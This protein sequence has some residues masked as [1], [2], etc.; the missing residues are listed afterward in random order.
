M[1]I[2]AQ[3][4]PPGV[5]NEEVCEGQPVPDLIATGDDIQWFDDPELTNLV[6]E[7]NQ[8]STGL[9]DPGTYTFYAV[10]TVNECL[11][12]PAEAV[13]TIH[14]LPAVTLAEINDLCLNAPPLTLS[15]G[16]PD[17]GTYSG[18]GVELNPATGGIAKQIYQL[19]VSYL[20]V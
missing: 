7:G 18:P 17:G 15:G 8:F 11:S 14:E 13:L 5:S 16:S 3:P 20:H 6:H 9:T 12:A 10:Q 2:S 19:S 4:A 1:T